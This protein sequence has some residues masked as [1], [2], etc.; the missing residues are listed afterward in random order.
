MFQQNAHD[1]RKQF[2]FVL[3]RLSNIHKLP[4][5]APLRMSPAASKMAGWIPKNGIVQIRACSRWRQAVGSSGGRPFQFATKY[6]L[7][8]I[9][10]SNNMIIPF[11]CLRINRFADTPK[12]LKDCSM[13]VLR[14]VTFTHKSTNCS[15]RGIENINLMFVNYFQI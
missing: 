14:I 4:S 5:A 15:R 11:P 1:H 12:I 8:G 2:A 7:L 6:P 13:F 10:L 9:C 3:A